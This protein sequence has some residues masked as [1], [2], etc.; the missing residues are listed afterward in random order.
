V[1]TRVKIKVPIWSREAVGI[2]NF[3]I[4][5]DIEVEVLYRDKHGNRRYPSVYFMQQH[6]ALS[7]PTEHFAGHDMK[8]IPIA[9]FSIIE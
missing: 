4:V 3:R 6:R 2:A 1:A 7:Y 5:D 9:D 8:I